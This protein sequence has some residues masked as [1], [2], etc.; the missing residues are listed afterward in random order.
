[1]VAE[2]KRYGEYS[3]PGEFIYDHPFQW[4][5]RR[6]GPDL[7]REGGLRGSGWHWSH[8]ENP[9]LVS[10]G[11][12]MPE[13]GHLLTA[14]LKFSAIQPLVV[15]SH[16]LGAEY[17]EEELTDADKHARKQAERVAADI[18]KQGGPAGVQEKQAIALIAYLQ[19]MGTDLFRTEETKKK[20]EGEAVPAGGT[21]AIEAPAAEP[22][23]TTAAL[24]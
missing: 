11:T 24:N 3:K 20:V 7:A 12:V 19:R 1:M 6:I 5:S 21:P 16:F 17:G 10:E 22:T 4:G 14:D 9:S 2:T 23:V 18:V 8:F 15:A 13:Y